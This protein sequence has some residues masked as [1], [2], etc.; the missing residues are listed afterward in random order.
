MLND[1][2]ILPNITIKV[3]KRRGYH[4]SSP[5][6]LTQIINKKNIAMDTNNESKY[7]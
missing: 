1:N 2:T 6:N 7:T 3:Q 5:H 4:I